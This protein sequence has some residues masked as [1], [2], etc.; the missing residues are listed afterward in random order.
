M[1]ETVKGSN[2]PCSPLWCV[3]FRVRSSACWRRTP[4][5]WRNKEQRSHDVQNR[6]KEITR[7]RIERDQAFRYPVLATLQLTYFGVCVCVCVCNGGAPL[8]STC[9]Y[10]FRSADA[11]SCLVC[12]MLWHISGGASMDTRPF[13]SSVQSCIR[14]VG[15]SRFLT[16]PGLLAC[17]TQAP[18]RLWKRHAT[19]ICRRFVCCLS[20]IWTGHADLGGREQGTPLKTA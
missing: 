3:G 7:E 18:C 12:V 11:R 5:L 19:Q 1:S 15:L 20:L 9:A 10:G 2:T 6:K 8:S 16:S 13:S 17:R 4:C 14:C